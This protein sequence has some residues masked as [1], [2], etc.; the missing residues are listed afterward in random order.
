MLQS[1]QTAEHSTKA[2]NELN[3]E[4]NALK[5]TVM[6]KGMTGR[7]LGDELSYIASKIGLKAIIGGS[8]YKILDYFKQMVVV[9]R[10]L[11]TGMTNLKRVS[12][13]TEAT[14][15]GFMDSA[16]EKARNLG[17]T[18]QQVIDAT[19]DFSRLGY[20]LQEASELAN[21]ALMYSNV[22]E[23]DIN[24]ASSDMISA[25]KAFDIASTDSIHVVDVFNKLGNEFAV[26]AANIGEGLSQSASALAV[27]GNDFE[28]SAAM[29][30]AITEITQ[31]ASSAGNA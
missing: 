2:F 3:A 24:Q 12:E 26:T 5:A 17:S 23:I 14:Y 20:S 13:E 27:A 1:A 8:V 21:N 15:R 30:T 7:S 19:T 6:S 25:L 22:G 11:D 10:E 28:E 9:V 4:F 16:A 31:D 29:I 18:M